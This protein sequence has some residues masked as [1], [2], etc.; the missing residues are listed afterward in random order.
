ML[1]LYFHSR[2]PL[3]DAHLS[4][5]TSLDALLWV[6]SWRVGSSLLLL[7]Y[8]FFRGSH[9]FLTPYVVQSLFMLLLCSRVAVLLKS[10]PFRLYDT[11]IYLALGIF[12]PL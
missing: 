4:F 5:F 10:T 9:W 6:V 11:G 12:V 3:L 1:L 8:F 2:F 7:L